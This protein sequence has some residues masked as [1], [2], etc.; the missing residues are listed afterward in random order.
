MARDKSIHRCV[1]TLRRDVHTEAFLAKWGGRGLY[2]IAIAIVT[3]ES[4]ICDSSPSDKF[5]VSYCHKNNKTLKKEK[6][7]KKYFV[8][9][10]CKYIILSV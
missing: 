10:Y 6:I 5:H 4:R 2:K 9:M 7:A 3:K 1:C 8:C